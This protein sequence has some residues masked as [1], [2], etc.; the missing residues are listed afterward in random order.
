MYKFL[1]LD[2][3]GVTP[4]GM[5]F[6]AS[7]SYLEGESLNNVVW[8][9]EWFRGLFLKCDALSGIIVINKDLALMNAV[10]TIFHEYTN[11]LC[12]F[13]IDKKNA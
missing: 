7:F 3:V 4:T 8:T 1:L 13:H 10:K 11:L 2:F 6:S 5:T 12:R 9:L